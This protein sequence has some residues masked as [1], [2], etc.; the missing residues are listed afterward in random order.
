[1][2]FERIRVVVAR[3]TNYF[4]Y[5]FIFLVEKDDLKGQRDAIAGIYNTCF[6]KFIRSYP[7]PIS[8]FSIESCVKLTRAPLKYSA[9]FDPRGGGDSTPGLFVNEWL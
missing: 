9:E 6:D 7:T 2:D 3:R 4:E 8:A 5:L 1:M